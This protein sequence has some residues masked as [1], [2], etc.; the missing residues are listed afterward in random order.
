MT[1]IYYVRHAESNHENRDDRQRELTP[2][3]LADRKKVTAFLAQRPINAIFSSPYKRA[4][5]T[6]D[7]FAQARGMDIRTM[8]EL[9]ERR[10][11]GWVE[12]F[13]SFAKAQWDDHDYKLPDGE[14]LREVQE[15]NLAAIQRILDD[16]Q[17]K[18][19]V[20]AGHGTALSTI[21]HFYAPTFGYEDFEYIRPRMPLIVEFTFEG[22]S[23]IGIQTHDL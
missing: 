6:V 8:E 21:I 13:S 23:C 10:V 14:S 16:Y 9:R 4:V 17:D 11:G 3:G 7:D 5:D 1:S 19:V 15:R 22:C 2:K 20:I 12:D 18:T